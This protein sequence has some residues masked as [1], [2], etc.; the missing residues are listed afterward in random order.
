MSPESSGADRTYRPI[1]D[2]GLIGD[3]GAAALVASDGTIDWCCLP[4][5]ESPALFARLLDADQGGYFAVSPSAP[6]ESE[7]E[8]LDRTNVL[9]TRFTTDAGE[10]QVTDFMP[11]DA[12]LDEGGEPAV[13]DATRC[14]FRRIEGLGGEVPIEVTVRPTVAWGRQRPAFSREEWGLRIEHGDRAIALVGDLEFEPAAPETWTAAPVVRQGD[15]IWVSLQYLPDRHHAPVATES[16]SYNAALDATVSYWRS[17]L[18]GMDYD[19]AYPDLV[20]RSALTLKLLVYAPSGGV[21]AAPTTSLP[22]EPGGVRNWDYR[23]VWLIDAGMV[24]RSLQH[25][26]FHSEAMDFWEWLENICLECGDWGQIV[27]TIE[28]ETQLPE[29]R[30]HHLDGYVGSKPVRVGNGAAEQRQLDRFGYI[31]EAAYICR[32]EMREPHPKLEPVLAEMADQ[33]CRRWRDPD[34][35]VW[36]IGADRRQYT[37]SKLGCWVALD[38][39]LRLAELG[40]L[41]GNPSRWRKNRRELRVVIEQF[42]YNRAL[43][44]FTQTLDGE[45]LDASALMIPLVGFLPA[46]DPRVE[47]TVERIREQLSPADGLLKRYRTGDGLPGED[48]A[49]LMCSFWLVSVLAEAGR[50]EEARSVFETAISY[51]NDL[52]LM[53]EELDPSTGQL[54]GNFP[55]AFSHLGLIEALQ[56]LEGTSSV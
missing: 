37:H 6:F 9:K 2:Y 33:A 7:R 23:F 21:V 20:R 53:S 46:S 34:H 14:I 50:P 10:I 48:G 35:G 1:A 39:A 16:S 49:F 52:G 15:T 17:W 12:D 43:G 47:S 51:T 19:G 18:D 45:N 8:Y 56:R 30:L 32:T 3:L 5:F 29:R 26:G 40:M 22:E 42:G 24:M 27:Y 31:L 54:L 28:G 55:Q 44:A 41:D 36:E 25:I 11:V 13:R 4:N 38:R